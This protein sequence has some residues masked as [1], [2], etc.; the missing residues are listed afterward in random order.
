MNRRSAT[1]SD[2]KVQIPCWLDSK[3][4]HYKLPS[5]IIQAWVEAITRKEPDVDVYR[6]PKSVVELL[7]STAKN[8]KPQCPVA[9]L[10]SSL[11]LHATFTSL[12]RWQYEKW[13]Y[14]Q[15]LWATRS[16]EAVQ[17]IEKT[18]HYKKL[19]SFAIGERILSCRWLQRIASA[20]I[21]AP[22]RLNVLHDSR[23]NR[24]EGDLRAVGAMS[25]LW[26]FSVLISLIS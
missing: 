2:K 22:K 17:S 12:L 3:R 25:W 26:I 14:G 23:A 1:D 18:S 16:S 24:K 5:G 4:Q 6:R 8:E 13:T 20:L 19:G 21:E 15:N 9:P 10:V 7:T 11:P